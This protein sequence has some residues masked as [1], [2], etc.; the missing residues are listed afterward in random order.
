MDDEQEQDGYGKR[1]L[2]Q[3]VL[4]YIVIG[5]VIYGAVYYF[6][7]NK[8]QSD[9]NMSSSSIMKPTMTPKPTAIMQKFSD[10]SDFQ[11]AYKIFPGAI[12]VESKQAMSGFMMIT[13]TLPDS[14]TQIVLT[15]QE[16]GYTSQQ[17]IVKPGDTLYFIERNLQ[18]DNPQEDSDA[19]S[20]DDTAVLVDSQG[21]IA[22]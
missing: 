2:W 9:Y 5:V 17:Y 10:S 21:Y 1:P 3:W 6:I 11:Y 18:D 4:L 13:K 22:Q 12:S 16:L 20:H 15:A 14:S 8:H 7:S 19:N